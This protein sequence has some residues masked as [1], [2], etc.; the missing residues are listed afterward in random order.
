MTPEQSAAFGDS[1]SPIFM[2]GAFYAI[3]SLYHDEAK[4][5]AAFKS[6]EGISWGD[7]N[8]CLF[9]RT[10]KFFSPSCQGNLISNW[11][12]SLD[13]VV[14]KLKNG[15]KEASTPPRPLL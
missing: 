1:D 6:G 10:E 7:D 12:A 3:I 8:T 14:D 9:C 5:R 15:A 11:L 13:G 4:L 2:T